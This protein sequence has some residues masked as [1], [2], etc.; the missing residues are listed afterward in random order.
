MIGG[1]LNGRVQEVADGVPAIQAP[2]PD[3]EP[4]SVHDLL[5]TDAIPDLTFRVVTYQITIVVMFG[6]ILEIGWLNG[7]PSEDELFGL[8]ASDLARDLAGEPRPDS[9]EL[10]ARRRR[11]RLREQEAIFGGPPPFPPA[12]RG[13]RAREVIVDDPLAEERWQ[14]ANR[15]FLRRNRAVPEPDYHAR[16]PRDACRTSCWYAGQGFNRCEPGE[17]VHGHSA[18][19]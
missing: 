17:C 15:E 14:A 7:R 11:G 5:D 2:V 18:T 6:R 8:L 4:M 19:G 9:V 3:P 12:R 1:P 16:M 13:E 10:W